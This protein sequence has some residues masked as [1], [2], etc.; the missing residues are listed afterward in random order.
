VGRCP[1]IRQASF[2]LLTV[3]RPLAILPKG[4]AMH[5]LT[6]SA[7]RLAAGLTSRRRP[8]HRSALRHLIPLAGVAGLMILVSACASGSPHHANATRAQPRHITA[9]VAARSS[10]PATA[11]SPPAPTTGSAVTTD[12]AG[13]TSSTAAGT[14]GAAIPPAGRA[15]P[16]TA[17]VVNGTSGTVTPIQT[18]TNTAGQA[19]DVQK[20]PY[21]IAITPNGKTAYVTNTLLNTVAPVSTATGTVGKPISAGPAQ[22][23]AI[24]PNGKTAYVAN[25]GSG[26]VTPIFTAT[27]TAGRPIPVGSFPWDIA[28]TPNG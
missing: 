17:Y 18:A 16:V 1:H 7:R 12:S 11:A 24:T 4:N 27:N 3:H 13:T 15:H 23:I 2:A 6:C 22:V 19:I 21:A 10:A 25:T 28:I 5:L 20:Y 8:S 26:T 14:P 9:A